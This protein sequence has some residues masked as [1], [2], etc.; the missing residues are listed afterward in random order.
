MSANGFELNKETEMTKRTRRR[1][2]TVALAPAAALA[3][4]ALIRLIGVDLVVSFGNG[5]VGPGSV[6]AAALIGA[7]VGWAAASLFERRSRRPRLWWSFAASTGLSVSM[8]GPSWLAD[9]SSAVALMALHFVTAIV[10]VVG[11]VGTI[12]F[13]GRA[14]R[15]PMSLP[16]D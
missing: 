16:A 2:A 4:W 13:S 3:A 11:L 15:R 1:I 8:I 9:G 7:L 14:E 5:K 12:P 10:V 6:V